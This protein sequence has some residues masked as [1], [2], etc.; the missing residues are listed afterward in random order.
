LA[1]IIRKKRIKESTEIGDLMGAML[2]LLRWPW[3]K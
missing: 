2:G 3:S 1:I